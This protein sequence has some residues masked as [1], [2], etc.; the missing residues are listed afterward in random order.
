M[1]VVVGRMETVGEE[2]RRPEQAVGS[3]TVVVDR[4][5][6]R[7]VGSGKA[8]LLDL[9]GQLTKQLETRSQ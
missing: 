5:Y 9:L 4:S 6:G 2:G 8:A 3:P 7:A 1:E